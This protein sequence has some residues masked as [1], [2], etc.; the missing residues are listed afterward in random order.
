MKD[1]SFTTEIKHNPNQNND[2]ALRTLYMPIIGVIPATLYSLLKDFHAMN[3]ESRT[4][5]PISSL[6]DALQISISELEVA[7]RKLEAVGLLR[8]FLRTDETKCIFMINEPLNPESFRKNSF[9]YKQAIEK[10]GEIA[11]EKVEFATKQVS[12]SKDDFAEVTAKYQDIF[13]FETQKEVSKTSSTQEIPLIKFESVEEAINGLNCFQFMRFLTNELVSPTQ[14]ATLQRIM[15]LGFA[16]PSINLIINYVFNVNGKIVSA[17]IETI[18]NDLASKKVKG[19]EEVK[20]ELNSAQK[21]KQSSISTFELES[22]VANSQSASS[23]KNE[24]AP[25]WDEIFNSLGGEL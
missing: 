4:Y 1:R 14:Q 3:K 10:I 16:N 11:F 21:S 25:S 18:A 22:P 2:I 23:K 7:L 19:F 6:I 24:D 5:D 9:L 20:I 12:L 17:H 15:Q 8:T 13:T